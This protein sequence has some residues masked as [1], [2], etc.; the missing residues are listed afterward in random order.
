MARYGTRRYSSGFKYGE[1]STVGVYYSANLTAKAIDYQTIQI[2]WTNIVPDPADP[3]PTHWKLV[4]SYVGT[5]D[6]PDDAIY[7]AGGT[8]AT[9][10]NTY[11]GSNVVVTTSG[12]NT[13]MSFY[14]S[15]TYTA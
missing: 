15:G 3:V 5:V 1:L 7:V 12:S 8:Y 6:N 2:T 9:F 10:S 14:A 11:T 13:I 4:K